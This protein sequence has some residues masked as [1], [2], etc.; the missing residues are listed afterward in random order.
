MT[1]DESTIS[2][3]FEPELARLGAEFG[4]ATVRGVISML[5]E[6]LAEQAKVYEAEARYFR[7][8]YG[9]DPAY[10]VCIDFAAI[11]QDLR[12]HQREQATVQLTQLRLT[13]QLN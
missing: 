9:R 2:K 12:A 7:Q 1:P 4:Q 3:L 13:A 8:R 6:Q 11:T 10:D 5:A